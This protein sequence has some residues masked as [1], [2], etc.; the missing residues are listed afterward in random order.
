MSK[1]EPLYAAA[2]TS[3]WWELRILAAHSHPSVAAFARTLLG[4]SFIVYNG[5]PLRDFTL[6][7]FLEKFVAKKPKSAAAVKGTS[8]M[9]PLGVV[10]GEEGAGGGLAELGSDAFAVLAEVQVE[11]SEIFFHR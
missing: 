4:G 8:V 10:K 6:P 3:C 11:P 9:Q 5:D 2:E 7:V 1:R